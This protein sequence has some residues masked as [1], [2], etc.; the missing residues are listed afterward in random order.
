VA[1]DGLEAAGHLEF[2]GWPKRVVDGEADHGSALA[3]T[4]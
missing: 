3:I 1:V 4:E 2:E